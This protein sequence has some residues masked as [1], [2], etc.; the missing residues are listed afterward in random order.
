TDG[1]PLWATATNH[2]QSWPKPSW[3]YVQ[4]TV[5]NSD[6][7]PN[8]L[9]AGSD[10]VTI[11]AAQAGAPSQLWQLA[12]DGRLLS[13]LL[14]GLVLTQGAAGSTGFAAANSTQAVPAPPD[15][16]WQCSSQLDVVSIANLGS[17][18]YLCATAAGEPVIVSDCDTPQQWY[19]IPANPL[20]AA[21]ALP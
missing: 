14:G 2:D 7:S 19:L 16:L 18:Q 5:A 13:G 6:G 15:Q 9:T 11:S 20:A 21:M 12:P 17:G 10:G 1:T 4:S 3:V 8:V